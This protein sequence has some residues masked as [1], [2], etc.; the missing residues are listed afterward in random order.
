MYVSDILEFYRARPGALQTPFH[1]LH[2]SMSLNRTIIGIAGAS[3][4]GKSLL[5]QQ[6]Y[7]RILASRPSQDVAILHEDNYYRAQSDLSFTERI[8]INYD[9]PA[10]LEH[11][12]LNEHLKK[13]RDGMIVEVPQ[14]DYTMHTRK[15]ETKRFESARVLI[16]EGILVLHDPELRANFD[17]KIFVDVPLDVCLLRRLKRDLQERGRSLD[18][19]LDQYETTVRP[20][21]YQFIEPTK[22]HADIIVPRG[23]ENEHALDVLNRYL[24]HLLS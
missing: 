14:Y 24:V 4:A 9:H 22:M 17:L 11:D 8:E 21:Y 18:S 1:D 3:G 7:S 19:I 15:P 13:L 20:M 23:G 16:V 6:L 5:A 10:A 12:L 2:H